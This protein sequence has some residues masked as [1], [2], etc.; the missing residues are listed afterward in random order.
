[1]P[2]L[3]G[4][5]DYSNL[6][7]NAEICASGKEKAKNLI[8]VPAFV[9]HGWVVLGNLQVPILIVLENS[10][11][12]RRYFSQNA[13]YNFQTEPKIFPSTYGNC[14]LLILQKFIFFAPYLLPVGL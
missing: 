11:N 5:S 9:I 13:A 7:V 6:A 2:R 10:S 3:K 4:F 14:L 8:E 1:M 12:E